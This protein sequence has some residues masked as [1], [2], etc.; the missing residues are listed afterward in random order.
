MG[1][2]TR[3][4][5][6]GGS[7]DPTFVSSL[8]GATAIS[9]TGSTACA[10]VEG[11]KVWGWGYSSNGALG[12][13]APPSTYQLDP[14]AISSVSA[15]TSVAVGPWQLCVIEN[16]AVNCRGYAR[17]NGGYA[18]SPD[19]VSVSST[20]GATEI[21]AGSYHSC[22]I[23]AGTAK[24]WG[25][26]NDVG[27]LGRVAVNP[28]DY[29]SP[30]PVTSLATVTAIST[31]DE[32]T[33]AIQ[34]D[35]TVKCWGLNTDGQLGNGKSGTGQYE[36]AAV[37]VAGLSGAVGIAV[38]SAHSCALLAGG[39]VKCWGSNACYNLGTTSGAQSTQPVEIPNL[40][41]VLELAAGFDHTCVRTA[42]GVKCWGCNDYGQLGRNVSI[43][44]TA[45][46]TDN[47]F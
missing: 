47:P 41:G 15:A 46:P 17:D 39:T 34:A 5:Y 37:Q 11:G 24:C 28:I 19:P 45:V 29:V 32:H 7:P 25:S 23:V 27:E 9:A 36:P 13:N 38:G 12:R 20:Q 3:L 6:P 1:N 40:G 43:Q 26:Q 31:I 44:K 8:S 14:V 35:T 4:S 21:V 16:G 2:G 10:L 30:A 33:C 42:A 22:A 18:D